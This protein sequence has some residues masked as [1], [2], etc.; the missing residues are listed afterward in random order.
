M[1]QAKFTFITPNGSRVEVYG[2]LIPGNDRGKVLVEL[3]RLKQ[4]FNTITNVNMDVELTEVN[5]IEVVDET[6]KSE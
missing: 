2:Q 1:I 3:Y 6:L 5:K 4:T